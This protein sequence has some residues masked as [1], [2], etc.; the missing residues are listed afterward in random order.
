MGHTHLARDIELPGGGRY[1]NTGTLIRRAPARTG[2]RC[3][4]GR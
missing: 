1:L 3:S 2:P 4:P